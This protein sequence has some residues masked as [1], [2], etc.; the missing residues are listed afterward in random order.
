[1]GLTVFFKK[2]SDFSKKIRVIQTEGLNIIGQARLDHVGG[3]KPTVC[4]VQL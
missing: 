3:S 2:V 4:R 1:M